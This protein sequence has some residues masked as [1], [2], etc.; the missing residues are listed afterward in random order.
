MASPFRPNDR[1]RPIS[2]VQ[3]CIEVSPIA[4][5]IDAAQ[6]VIDK[7]ISFA[8][9]VYLFVPGICYRSGRSRLRLN[10]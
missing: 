4:D 2:G 9:T 8:E 1:L 7:C 3:G 5:E 6:D 10:G